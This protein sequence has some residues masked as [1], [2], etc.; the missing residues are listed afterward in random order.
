MALNGVLW[1]LRTGAQW[2]DLPEKYGNYKTVH[3]RFQNWSKQGVFDQLLIMLAQDLRDPSAVVERLGVDAI[4]EFHE[5]R[6][7]GDEIADCHKFF[8]CL[9]AHA[10]V[11]EVVGNFRIFGALFGRHDVNRFG[12]LY[13]EDVFATMDD[14]A[15]SSECFWIEATDRI[16]ANKTFVIDVGDDEADLIHVSGGDAFLF[17]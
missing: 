11:G 4:A 17:R 12:S 5:C 7:A 15:L 14:H 1:I 3:R 10:G 8:E 9:C 2:A 6:I 16:E 13:A